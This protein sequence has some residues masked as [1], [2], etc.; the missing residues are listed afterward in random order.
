ML[1]ERSKGKV[2]DCDV[3]QFQK[4]IGKEEQQRIERKVKTRVEAL[5]N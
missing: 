1:D 2:R 4:A 5:Q 3:R